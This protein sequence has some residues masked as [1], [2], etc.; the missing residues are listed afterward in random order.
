MWRVFSLSR[1]V[2]FGVRLFCATKRDRPEGSATQ[3]DVA[4]ALQRMG[5][6]HVYEHFEEETGISLD[7][8]RPAAR[9]AVEFDGPV[10]YFAND[11]ERL[12]GRSRLKRRLLALSGWKV[13][14][15]SYHEWE[16]VNNQYECIRN[17][18]ARGGLQVPTQ[19]LSQSAL[20]ALRRTTAADPPPGARPETPRFFPSKF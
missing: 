1:V 14:F 15:V 16:G 8:A 6:D 20:D 10:H 18:F 2:C 5:W 3:G 11:R 17:A 19:H 13:A 12:T 4:R 9:E 7:M